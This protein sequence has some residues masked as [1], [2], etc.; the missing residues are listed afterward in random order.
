MCDFIAS[1]FGHDALKSLV[2]SF[3]KHEPLETALQNAVGM[4]SDGLDEAFFE[5]LDSRYGSLAQSLDDYVLVSRE[6]QSALENESWDTA[7][8][9]GEDLI[10]RYP[11]NTKPG[12]GYD[13]LD[14]AYIALEDTDAMLDNRWRWFEQGGHEPEVL[15]KLIRDLRN[16][17]RSDDAVEVIK[18][19]NWVTPYSPQEHAWLGTHFLEQNDADGALREYN[20]LLAVTDNNPAEA[21][22]GRA[23]AAMISDDRESAREEVLYA[24][25]A[26]P[27]YRPAQRLLLDLTAGN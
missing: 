26:S 12:G 23:Q 16:N 15:K 13:V 21:Y 17:A 7:I 25:E 27:F 8:V 10:D 9:L 19:L 11:E 4:D 3:A 5:F 14:A 20:A 18:A 22:L 6:A 1:R 2:K 24:L